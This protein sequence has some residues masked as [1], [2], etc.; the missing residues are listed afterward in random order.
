MKGC[1]TVIAGVF[2]E[3]A[4]IVCVHFQSETRRDGS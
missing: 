1:G 4:V 3:Q 2:T